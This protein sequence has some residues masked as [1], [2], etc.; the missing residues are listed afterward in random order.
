MP[1]TILN[2]ILNGAKSV[3]ADGKENAVKV[4]ADS[5]VAE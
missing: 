3:T 2:A 1:L 5:A 4:R